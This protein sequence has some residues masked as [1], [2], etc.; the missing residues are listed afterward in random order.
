MQNILLLLIVFLKSIFEFSLLLFE[1]SQA[2]PLILLLM[3]SQT[4]CETFSSCLLSA[5]GIWIS[6]L[7]GASFYEKSFNEGLCRIQSDLFFKHSTQLGATH[8][9][10]AW[11]TLMDHILVNR[12]HINSNHSLNLKVYL[13]V[14]LFKMT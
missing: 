1:N 5:F 9:S 7:L 11:T 12:H 2:I 10:K 13:K 4:Q 14:R 6:L 8:F 3:F